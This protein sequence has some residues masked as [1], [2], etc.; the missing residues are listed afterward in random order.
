MNHFKPEKVGTKVYGKMMKRMQVLEEGRIL[1]KEARNWWNEL[2]TGGF[3]AQKGLW[4]VAKEKCWKTEV[5]N[6]KK[7]EIN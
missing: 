2:E 3:M 7:T 5:L 4:N 1:A 6:Q